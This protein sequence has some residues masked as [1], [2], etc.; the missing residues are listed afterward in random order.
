MNVF[1]TVIIILFLFGFFEICR[2]ADDCLW[3][4]TVGLG[5]WCGFKGA[6]RRWRGWQRAKGG[7]WGDYWVVL[8]MCLASLVIAIWITLIYLCLQ[9]WLIFTVSPSIHPTTHLYTLPKQP[10]KQPLSPPQPPSHPTT[11][12]N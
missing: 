12:Y 3:E 8:G 6:W 1:F 4:L 9:L 5:R 2:I 11:Y 10:P 7:F